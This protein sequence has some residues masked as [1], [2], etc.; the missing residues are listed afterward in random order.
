MSVWKKFVKMIRGSAKD[1]AE[2]SSASK[3]QVQEEKPQ[4]LQQSHPADFEKGSLK[5][6]DLS[7]EQL[8]AGTEDSGS[9]SETEDKVEAKSPAETEN[10][11]EAERQTET[12]S[13]DGAERQTET[14][15]HDG[16]ERL[17]EAESPAELEIPAEPSTA[18]E[19]P[20]EQISVETRV[21]EEAETPAEG[22]NAGDL[23][24]PEAS[25]RMAAPD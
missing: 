6:A 19:S 2:F 13:H 18:P 3:N 1:D 20:A 8:T 21:L 24:M 15:S 23:E 25:E 5:A 9:L 10:H 14:E 4:E 11:V 22:K 12:E 17:T 7:G 16:A